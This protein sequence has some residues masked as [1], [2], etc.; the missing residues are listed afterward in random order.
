MSVAVLAPAALLLALGVAGA[1][2]GDV[3][4][5]SGTWRLVPEEGDDA[6]AKL[7]EAM[8]KPK[9]GKRG[10]P[11]GRGGMPP[12]GGMPMGGGPPGEGREGPVGDPMALMREVVEPPALMTITQDSREILIQP[13]KANATILRPDGRKWKRAGGSIETR[14]KWEGSD[15]VAESKNRM[16]KV[17]TTFSLTSPDRLVITHRL[18]PRRGSKTTVRHVYRSE[19]EDGVAPAIP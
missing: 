2:A 7:R 16:L 15:L 13:E 19:T 10:F 18:K 8:P 12:P 6:K 11:G 9:E 5:L 1:S 14:T 3:P 4:Q 17:T